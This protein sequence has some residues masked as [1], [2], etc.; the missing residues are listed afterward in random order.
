MSEVE[1][2]VAGR[3]A[4]IALNRPKRMNALDGEMRAAI[5]AR[6]HDAEADAAVRVVVITG[7]GRAFCAGG[8]L[9]AIREKPDDV[10]AS[11]EQAKRTIAAMRASPKPIVARIN[12]PAIGA[13]MNLALACDLRI[14]SNRATLGQPYLKVG[15][16]PDWGGT[17]FLPRLIGDAEARRLLLTGEVVTAAEALRLGLVSQVVPEAKLDAAIMVAAIQLGAVSPEALAAAKRTLYEEE[18][19]ALER[20]LDREAAAQ[21]SCVKS[22]QA[23][24]GIEA[25]LEKRAPKY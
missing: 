15:L 14:A 24:E 23:A 12:G 18:R 5:E 20:A 9:R 6:L 19:E 10:P 17:F 1:Y 21:A 7:R 2:V 3:V 16:H 11:L 8:D 22:A 25:F 13:G 4:T